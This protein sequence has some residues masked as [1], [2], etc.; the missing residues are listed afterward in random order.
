MMPEKVIKLGQAPENGRIR[1]S[2]KKV[3]IQ[4]SVGE[5]FE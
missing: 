3:G 4:E 1:V 5:G 2:A